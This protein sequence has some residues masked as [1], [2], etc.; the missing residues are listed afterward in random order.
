MLVLRFCPVTADDLASWLEGLEVG[1]RECSP[2]AGDLS[3]RCYFRIALDQG[4]SLLAAYYPESLRAAMVRFVAARSLLAGAG[5]RVPEILHSSVERGLMLV[6]DLG[7]AT[8]FELSGGPSAER[9]ARFLAAVQNAGRIA[10]LDVHEVERLGNP[11]LDGAL[12]RREIEATFEYLLDPGGLADLAADRQTLR[13]ALDALCARLGG[14]RLVPCHRD[15]MARN[16][17]PL[18]E[19]VAVIDF[20]DLR[21]GP[22]AYDLASLLNDSFFPEPALEDLL[23]PERWRAGSA[24]DQYSRAV[25]QRALKAAGTFARFAAQGNPRHVPLI[26]PTLARAAR[27]LEVLPETSGAYRQLRDWWTSQLVPGAI[28]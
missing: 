10:E 7:S 2:L 27:H 8:L 19:G 22:P 1:A 9:T 20:Q 6:E 18:G 25:V 17:I 16:L 23:L 21:L 14:D 11:P 15:F 12:L 26:A 4:G 28:C 24:C 5:V 3:Q 13:L